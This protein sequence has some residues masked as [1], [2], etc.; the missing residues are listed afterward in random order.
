MKPW[1]AQCWAFEGEGRDLSAI[2]R[3]DDG[4]EMSVRFLSP[5]MARVTFRPRGGWREPRTWAIAPLADAAGP[6]GSFSR[7][8]PWH[9]RARDDLAGFE[10]SPVTGGRVDGAD[11]LATVRLEVRLH[12]APLRLEWRAVGAEQSVAQD[13]STS[14]YLRQARTGAVRH[15]LARDPREHFYGLG[16]KTGRLNLHGRRLRTAAMDSLGYDPE[17]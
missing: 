16:D 5:T 9:G 1:Q 12:V 14:A 15:Y 4:A 2:C 10:R 6:G 8:V 11:T 7:D 3:L 17:H 13:R